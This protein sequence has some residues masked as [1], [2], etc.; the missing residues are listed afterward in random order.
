MFNKVFKYDFRFVIN[1]WCVGAIVA[2][3]IS[4]LAGFVTQG[5]H[6]EHLKGQMIFSLF[7]GFTIALTVITLFAFGIGTTILI[8]VRYYKNFFS[9]EGYLTFTLPVPRTTLL[10]SKFLLA[11]LFGLMTFLVLALDLFLIFFIGYPNALDYI[12]FGIKTYIH[13]FSQNGDFP[14]IVTEYILL[15]I[16]GAIMGISM[17]F[18][19][20]TFGAI[21]AKKHKILASIGIYYGFNT[22]IGILYQLISIPLITR[23]YTTS[24]ETISHDS[25]LAMGI[26]TV[27]SAVLAVVFYFM[28][29][30]WIKKK[31]N[32]S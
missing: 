2:T 6:S 12:S 31:L 20:I 3:A 26:Y 18:F 32:L 29:L 19:A 9:D 25:V 5:F 13:Q 7:G 4:V 14:I 30:Q 21:M 16:F 10:L 1:L 24:Y 11:L 23:S 27:L 22:G 8:L 17:A 15:I 28:N